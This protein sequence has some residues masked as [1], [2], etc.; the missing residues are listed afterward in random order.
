MGY[1]IS[2]GNETVL[3]SGGTRNVSI[4]ED[5]LGILRFLLTFFS[6]RHSTEWLANSC[7]AV[8]EVHPDVF[9]VCEVETAFF[10]WSFLVVEKFS[11]SETVYG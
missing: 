2:A 3:R 10:C 1:P 9:F 11:R 4:P 8:E 6:K 5:L 7:A